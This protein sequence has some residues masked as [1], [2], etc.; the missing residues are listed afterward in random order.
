MSNHFGPAKEVKVRQN[1]RRDRENRK[2]NRQKSKENKTNG[3]PGE[4]REVGRHESDS[5]RHE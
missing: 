5:R 1:V 4:K 2:I 3:N